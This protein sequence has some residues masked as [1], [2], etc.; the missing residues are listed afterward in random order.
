MNKSNYLKLLLA[1]VS[2]FIFFALLLLPSCIEGIQSNPDA[3]FIY[4]IIV[5]VIVIGAFAFLTIKK[6][7]YLSISFIALC[8][9]YVIIN[10]LVVVTSLD[11]SSSIKPFFNSVGASLLNCLTVALFL[12]VVHEFFDAKTIRV[13]LDMFIAF[14]LIAFLYSVIA[15]FN[16][17]VKSFTAS[18][19]DAH[20]YQVKSIFD[21][22]NQYGFLLFSA[23]FFVFYLKNKESKFK[24][25]VIQDL[26]IFVLFVGVVLSRSKLPLLFSTILIA[27]Y[28]ALFMVREFKNRRPVF[29]GWAVALT[30]VI[31]ASI[32]L[33]TVPALYNSTAFTAKLHNYVSEAF[34]GQAIR[35]F[36]YRLKDYENLA[37]LFTSWRIIFGYG[38]L[39]NPIEVNGEVVLANI[40]NTFVSTLVQGG[41]IQVLL[42]AL[43]YWIVIK[44]LLVL[45]HYNK[46]SSILFFIS[47]GFTFVYG[48]FESYGLFGHTLFN[49]ILLISVFMIPSLEVSEERLLLKEKN[50]VLHV[51]GSFDQGG[52]E[53]FILSYLTEIREHTDM[54]FD[55]YCF[56][57][58]NPVMEEKLN[59]L[60]G[61]VFK[62]I[63]PSK[64]NMFKAKK[65]FVKFLVEHPE[66][67]V[68]HCSA[69]FDS[70]IYLMAAN[71]LGLGVRIGHAHD[72]LTGIKRNLFMKIKN[73]ICRW[74]ATQLVGC[75]LEAGKDIFGN[76][77]SKKGIVI[78]NSI[79]L[80]K[81]TGVNKQEI[82][83]LIK[84][85]N[86]AS[87]IV[88]G[89]ISRF[90]P[91]KNQEFIV[92]YF[93]KIHGSNKDTALILGGVDGGD[94][95]KI[96]NLV[97]EKGLEDCVQF[98]GPRDDVPA[99]LNVIDYYL[100]PSLFE[101]FGISALEAQIAGCHVLISNNFPTSIDLKLGNLKM[102]NLDIDKWVE[103]T[104]FEKAILNKKSG[105]VNLGDFDITTNYMKL[106]RLYGLS[107][108]Q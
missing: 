92:N 73:V 55:I 107:N 70:A 47:L 105:P 68:I 28:F 20:Y 48:L 14:M 95:K 108:E 90:E 75:S 5:S 35:S 25:N 6:R 41:I 102:L 99:W 33:V 54:T 66:Y 67:D 106:V 11:L 15:E 58:V 22:R 104:T 42:L 97:K 13:F 63:A 27:Y 77:F 38:A 79:N 21:G 30:V 46:K 17:I 37:P 85:Y 23:I 49:V 53:T 69:N 29:I 59:N 1:P 98:I 50:K 45:R 89:N 34:I 9:I 57:N 32:L 74:N 103:E 86:L 62:G 56:N 31:L 40:D 94:L 8:C 24:I 44:K 2:L 26:I 39:I 61:K 43:V 36:K 64:K 10:L 78:N 4:R 52:T 76:S 51:V 96:Q 65:E 82:D 12:F 7:L 71:E 19:E 16:T 18:G 72:I 91:K 81:F 80:E 100:M 3:S 88:F 83:N 93:E 60:G 87:K 101:G 84:Q